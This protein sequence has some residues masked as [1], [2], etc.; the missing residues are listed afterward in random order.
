MPDDKFQ[1]TFSPVPNFVAGEQPKSTKYSRWAA[2]TDAALAMLERAV[3]NM[4]ASTIIDGDIRPMLFT[5]LARSIGNMEWVNPYI[6]ANVDVLNHEEFT[7]SAGRE[8]YLDLFPQDSSYPL[9]TWM[10]YSN[11]AAV[12][13]GQWQTSRADL[14][15]NGDWTHIGRKIYTYAELG[16]PIIGGDDRIVRYHGETREGDLG[17]GF[18][19]FPNLSQVEAGANTACTVTQRVDGFG[20]T[21]YEVDMP[22]LILNKQLPGEIA[23]EDPPVGSGVVQ[24]ELP[25]QCKPP[26]GLTD[27]E[28]PGYLAMLWDVGDDRDI[29]NMSPIS[30]N[31]RYFAVSATRLEIRNATL[32]GFASELDGEVNNTRY[33]LVT[34]GQSLAEAFGQMWKRF[35]NHTHGPDS[36]GAPMSHTDLAET[37]FL[38][39]DISNNPLA[40]VKG[41]ATQPLIYNNN[42]PQFLYREGYRGDDPGTYYNSMLGNLNLAS[43]DE[44]IALDGSTDYHANFD[45]DTAKLTFFGPTGPSIFYSTPRGGSTSGQLERL[46]FRSFSIDG[47]VNPDTL[48]GKDGGFQFGHASDIAGA[49][50]DVGNYHKLQAEFLGPVD[51][52][53]YLRVRQR[54]GGPAPI[55]HFDASCDSFVIECETTIAGDLHITG[56]TDITG[57]LDVYG[58]IEFF[59]S[60]LAGDAFRIL[61]VDN[62]DD[63]AFRFEGGGATFS[64]SVAVD[65]TDGDVTFDGVDLSTHSHRQGMSEGGRVP[66][67]GI[68]RV[69]DRGAGY[70]PVRINSAGYAVYAP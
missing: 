59:L 19:V 66:V 11:D 31:A 56:D 47:N 69:G 64:R 44:N 67:E 50:A 42:H 70:T 6:P 8:L 39:L 52:L 35:L 34:M 9:G 45:W 55:I 4:W 49:P 30:F 38:Q 23:Y 25:E 17:M 3:G 33:V 12:V 1:D 41:Y 7:P 13:P 68:D 22:Y 60:D 5:S 48:T 27:D 32:E 51:I 40:W 26:T 10:V 63:E 61:D 20:E 18:N 2:Q 28:I 16:T 24:L 58:L 43:S 21:Y 37:V 62:A 29:P 15:A 36:F 57:D 54:T 65:D 46:V 53:N 14:A